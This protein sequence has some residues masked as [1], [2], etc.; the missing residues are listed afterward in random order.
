ME[1]VTPKNLDELLR[2][3]ECH[4]R[5]EILA[6]G[7]DICVLI[8]SGKLKPEGLINIRGL[9]KLRGIKEEKSHVEIGALTTHRNIVLS[10]VVRKH[11]PTLAEACT[12]VG[13]TQIQNRGTIGGNVMNASPAGDSLPV[14][15][16]YDA[17]VEAVSVDGKRSI[18]FL[19]FYKGYRKTAL[20]ENE[21]ITKFKIPKAYAD[22]K[23]LFVKIGTRRAQ[24]ISKVMGC[25]RL[26]SDGDVAKSVAITFGSIAPVPVRLSQTEKL[27]AGN[28]LDASLIDKVQKSVEKEVAPIDDIRSTAVYRRHVCGVLA[29]RFLERC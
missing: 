22:E 4:H 18:P 7:T 11:L 24:A 29:K 5:Y 12:T 3:V 2:L 8:N 23:S 19:E 28:R 10:S 17:E 9:D 27:I 6:G 1:F 25:F 16:A 21:I 15:L 13:A 26:V 14:L 20:R